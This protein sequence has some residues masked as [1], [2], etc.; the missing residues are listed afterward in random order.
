MFSDTY[1]F[2]DKDVSVET[3]F[4]KLLDQTDKVLSKY[5][6]DM[7]KTG[8]TTHEL[9]TIASMIEMEG[10]NE[11]DRNNIASVIYNRLNLNMSLGIDATTYYGSKVEIGSRE[12]YQ[13]ELNANNLYNTRNI[14]M[15]G[16][17]PV[18]PISSI[19]ESSIKAAIYPNR[20]SYTYYASDKERNVYFS[21][22]YAEHVQI[23][24]N[25]KS[26]GKWYEF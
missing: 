25:L 14:Y 13:Y 12:L 3:I 23:I 11:S 2:E 19:S 1:T 21:E 4:E 7:Q 15:Q 22:T 8:Y 26:K 24:N 18:G 9:I 20:T 10:V 16:K 6:V 17:L 5:R